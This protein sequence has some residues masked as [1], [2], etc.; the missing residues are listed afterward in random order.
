MPQA[1]LH[2]YR[3]NGNV[4]LEV[5]PL[6]D[7]GVLRPGRCATVHLRIHNTSYAAATIDGVSV[8][9]S[10]F[11][12]GAPHLP[13]SLKPSTKVDFTITF[14]A[15]RPGAYSAPLQANGLSTLLVA[16]VTGKAAR[17]AGN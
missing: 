12:L 11:T 6:L 3:V 4:E 10:G 5:G 13:V 15:F 1:R 9:G 16:S 8:S 14:E 17:T 7:L 2:L